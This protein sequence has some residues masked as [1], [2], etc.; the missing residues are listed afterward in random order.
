MSDTPDSNSQ[1]TDLVDRLRALG[2]TTI[3]P[4]VASA[5]LTAMAA[6]T[7]TGP[8]LRPGRERLARAKVAAAFAAGAGA[9]T[10]PR[11]VLFLIFIK[12]WRGRGSR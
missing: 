4:A 11:T 3:D 5:H 10:A 2:E 8:A 9:A 7:P 6:V 12:G 1:D